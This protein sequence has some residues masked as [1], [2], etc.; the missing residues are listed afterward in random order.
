MKKY[1]FLVGLM[2]CPLASTWAQVTPEMLDAIKDMTASKISTVDT[3]KKTTVSDSAR[4][5]DS[6]K[7]AKAAKIIA[8]KE[9]AIKAPR[10]IY[11][12]EGEVV[13]YNVAED[14]TAKGLTALDALQNA[15]S[16]EV[17][18]EGNITL[19]GSENVEIWLNGY[20]THIDG[21]ALKAYLESIPADYID[22]IEVIRNPSAKYMVAEGCHI[23][24]IVTSTKMRHSHFLALGLSASSQPALRPWVSYVFQNDK[25]TANAYLGYSHTRKHSV[26]SS[27][28]T[29]RRDN[30]TL[31]YDTTA[32]LN[33]NDEDLQQNGIWN[34]FLNIDYKADSLNSIGLFHFSMLNPS[35]STTETFTER[36]DFWPV[37]RHYAWY[38]DDQYNGTTANANTN[39]N[40]KHKLD[41]NGRNLSVSLNHVCF[42]MD[43]Q[44]EMVRQ[45][46]VLAGSLP[47]E[48]QSYAKLLSSNSITHNLSLSGNYNRPVGLDDELT[49]RLN[50][51][52]QWSFEMSA[53]LFYDPAADDYCRIDTLRQRQKHESGWSGSAAANWRHKWE[54]VTLTMGLKGYLRQTQY[55]IESLFPDDSTFSFATL[56]PSF[57]LTYR[58][59]SMHYFR[60]SYSLSTSTPSSSN[61]TNSRTYKEDGYNVG[62]PALSASHTHSI[63]ISW[64]KYF[65]S[66]GSLEISGYAKISSD[67]IT[68]CD[69]VT[70]SEDPYLGRFVTFSMPFNVGSSYSTG[71]ESNATYRATAWLNFRLYANLY[72]SGYEIDYPKTGLVH[73]DMTSWKL[74]LNCWTKIAKRVRV[75]V[76]ATYGSPTLSLFSEKKNSTDITL[77]ISSDFWQKRISAS[78]NISDLFNW[79]RSETWNTNPYIISYSNQHRDSRFITAA[80][81]I[82]LGKMNLQYH[83]HTGSAD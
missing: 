32:L 23:I 33:S 55:R 21:N 36:Q 62:N 8:L 6:L 66:R 76:S 16:V 59:P 5:A 82:N 22:R 13:S 79:N 37:M 28:N 35:Q 54:S 74:R 34:C 3:A 9:I 63:N 7:A 12:M 71:I 42:Y 25:L 2:L 68:I 73:S 83:A 24:N 15:P 58:T 41:N 44:N 75:N 64:N 45:Y 31:G 40:W 46:E 19:R 29:L 81:T 47:N 61:L 27:S 43:Q 57:D 52:R 14:E 80:V 39:L 67:E 11:S 17:D 65:K 20:P 10:P 50:A 26:S 48:M 60:F 77:G 56:E 49:F 72:R 4:V 78:I 18:I 70:S 69:D 53:P 30:G 38:D 51:N 1:V